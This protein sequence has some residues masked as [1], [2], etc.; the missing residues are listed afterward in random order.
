M[1]GMDGDE[2]SM[3]G[4]NIGNQNTRRRPLLVT[5][6]WRRPLNGD[7]LAARDIELKSRAIPSKSEW[8]FRAISVEVNTDGYAF[9]QDQMNQAER[10]C[11]WRGKPV[12]GAYSVE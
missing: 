11:Q 7:R 12:A 4:Q 5:L 3:H 1:R 2:I 9:R 10:V 8:R 6:E